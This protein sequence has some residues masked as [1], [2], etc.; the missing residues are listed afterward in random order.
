MNPSPMVCVVPSLS[1]TSTAAL[2]DDRLIADAHARD[3]PRCASSPTSA[4]SPRSWS[5]V[6]WALNT[7][8]NSCS[9][10]FGSRASREHGHRGHGLL[11]RREHAH[12]VGDVRLRLI[13]VRRLRPRVLLVRFDE[14]REVPG[15]WRS[16]RPGRRRGVVGG[17]A[18]ALLPSGREVGKPQDTSARE[19]LIG[20]G[21]RA[22]HAA[23]AGRGRRHCE[24]RERQ[25]S[26]DAPHTAARASAVR[27]RAADASIAGVRISV[28]S[29]PVVR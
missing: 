18:P 4:A 23:R 13:E 6:S 2:V 3:Q 8:V 19:F 14:R 22:G 25:D 29:S 9:R 28:R 12:R 24:Q 21:R 26:P 27:S 1:P 20:C 15:N 17:T 10:H 7:A 5:C 16:W 11:G